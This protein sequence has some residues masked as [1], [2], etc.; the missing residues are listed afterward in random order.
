MLTTWRLSV[1]SAWQSFLHQLTNWLLNCRACKARAKHVPELLRAWTAVI[2]R[3]FFV[4]FFFQLLRILASFR[5]LYSLFF[6]PII[7][8][9]FQHS[10][11]SPI[12][13]ELCSRG[14]ALFLPLPAVVRHHGG[15]GFPAG[16]EPLP[17]GAAE[18]PW[19]CGRL[20]HGHHRQEAA[21]TAE[22]DGAAPG[23][24]LQVGDRR[25]LKAPSWSS[26]QLETFFICQ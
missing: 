7:P 1:S 8:H 25:Q 24:E 5:L 23:G 14:P 18:S 21:A 10:I 19:L 12:S 9:F 26:W 13:P 2:S 11:T 6:P 15:E 22:S 4:L 16:G 20:G 17:E 3:L